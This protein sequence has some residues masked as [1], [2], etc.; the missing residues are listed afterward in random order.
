MPPSTYAASEPC[1][2]H[3]LRLKHAQGRL[4][5]RKY[6]LGLLWGSRPG[7]TSRQRTLV[8]LNAARISSGAAADQAGQLRG[9]LRP[10]FGLDRLGPHIQA[11]PVDIDRERQAVAVG[12]RAAA[13]RTVS[14]RSTER[15]A[16]AASALRFTT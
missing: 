10:A 11:L 7:A 8:S 13:G 9:H 4:V 12:D 3:A 16:C 1:G 14:V 2:Q 15:S 6:L 5:E